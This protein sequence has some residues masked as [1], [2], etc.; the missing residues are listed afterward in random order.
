MV[1]ILYL[2]LLVLLAPFLTAAFPGGVCPG[3]QTQA[4]TVAENSGVI[5][6]D[7]TSNWHSAAHSFFQVEAVSGLSVTGNVNLQVPDQDFESTTSI[8]AALRGCSDAG[9][10]DCD[11]SCLTITVTDANEAPVITPSPT[12]TINLNENTPADTVLVTFSH[13]DPD[14]GGVAGGNSN[15]EGVSYSIVASTGGNHFKI[16]GSQLQVDTPTNFESPGGSTT[17][18]VTVRGVNPKIGRAHV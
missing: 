14:E 16:V 7:L 13:T 10:T 6:I 8:T 18:S 3:G 17:K 4:E 2:C 5:S 15:F 9:F 11:V 1:P 12:G